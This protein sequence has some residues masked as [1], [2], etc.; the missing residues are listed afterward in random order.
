MQILEQPEFNSKQYFKQTSNRFF[1]SNQ[2]AHKTELR[3]IMIELFLHRYNLRNLLT[4]PVSYY[5]ILMP[6]LRL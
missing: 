1:S 6:F 4:F 3:G 2:I 5:T